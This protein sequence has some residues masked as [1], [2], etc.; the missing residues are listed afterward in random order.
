[1]KNETQFVFELFALKKIDLI[2]HE[3]LQMKLD[4]YD[5]GGFLFAWLKSYL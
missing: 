5:L 2:N 4:S 1:M 3:N